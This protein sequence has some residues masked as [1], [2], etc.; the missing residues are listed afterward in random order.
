MLSER[1]TSLA[2]RLADFRFLLFLVNILL[3]GDLYLLLVH[4]YSLAAATYS[5]L[6]RE[7]TLGDLVAFVL[8]YSLLLVMLAPAMRACAS[9]LSAVFLWIPWV[10]RAFETAYIPEDQLEAFAIL[11]ANSAAYQ[12]LESLRRKRDRMVALGNLGFLTLLFGIA[13]GVL[14]S[15]HD[16]TA[17]EA[18]GRML[19]VVSLPVRIPLVVCLLLLTLWMVLLPVFAFAW[20]NAYLPVNRVLKEAVERFQKERETPRRGAP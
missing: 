5:R 17:I 11:T 20:N 4:D 13:E 16:D 8:S 3:F 19:T 18:I 10:Q 14:A 12:G 2:E 15:R 7:L 9:L 1:V 6:S